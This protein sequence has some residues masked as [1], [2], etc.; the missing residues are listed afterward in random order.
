MYKKALFI[1]TIFLLLQNTHANSD[2]YYLLLLQDI[3]EIN[4]NIVKSIK[5]K[6][7]PHNYKEKPRVGML[8]VIMFIF[9]VCG[10]YLIA[11]GY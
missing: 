5:S 9:C 6:I 11:H 8:V 7:K 10:P 2:I 4:D 3:R 1:V